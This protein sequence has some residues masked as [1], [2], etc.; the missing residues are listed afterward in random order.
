M[1]YNDA[2]NEQISSEQLKHEHSIMLFH[3]ENL[4]TENKQLKKR[5]LER[6]KTYEQCKFQIVENKKEI[7]Q[8]REQINQLQRDNTKKTNE[9]KRIGTMF[10]KINDFL[11]PEKKS[12]IS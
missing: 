7:I 6:E 11:N 5:K 12:E 4:E 1:N 2:I 9:L 3:S 10:Q 8:L